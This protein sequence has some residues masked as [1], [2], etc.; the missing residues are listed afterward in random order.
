[1]SRKKREQRED[2]AE[3]YL[4]RAAAYPGPVMR[5]GRPEIIFARICERLEKEGSVSRRQARRAFSPGRGWRRAALAAMV[6]LLLF[7]LMTGGAFA[8]SYD[9]SPASSLY[10]TKLFFERVRLSLTPSDGA[11]VSY[12][13][14][15]IDKRLKELEGMVADGEEGGGAAWE[16][17]YRREVDGLLSQ[18]AGL[19]EGPRERSM[20]EAEC[21]L[22]EQAR[23]MEMLGP[24]AGGGLGSHLRNAGEFCE[25]AA[26]CMRE[27]CSQRGGKGVEQLEGRGGHPQD[28]S[29][30]D[31]ETGNG[32][33]NGEGAGEGGP[34]YQERKDR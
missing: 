2:I 34:G 26:R 24:A 27:G 19:P 11:K 28:G 22:Q 12:R 15:L 23:R 8:F 14:Q 6:T 29:A 4:R 31:G 21:R 3:A 1:M 17:A 25:E 7:T 20:E 10:G 30:G 5:P 9:A 13:L 32:E 33:G 18:I 16:A